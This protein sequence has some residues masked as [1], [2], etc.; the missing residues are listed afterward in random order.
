MTQRDLAD[1][2]G[3]SHVMLNYLL[4]GKNTNIR[5]S[6]LRQIHVA[7]GIPYETLV[8]DLLRAQE[9]ARK[10]AAPDKDRAPAIDVPAGL[11][12]DDLSIAD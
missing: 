7:T 4:R 2:I 5:I 6:L 12:E 3:L 10:G 11:D 8:D 9:A 1:K